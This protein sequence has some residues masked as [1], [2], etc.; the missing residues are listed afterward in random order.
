MKK[1][2]AIALAGAIMVTGASS[3]AMTTADFDRGMAKGLE[4]VNAG[5]YAEAKDEFQWFCDYNWWD[6]NYGQQQYALDCLGQAKAKAALGGGMTTQ[7]FDQGMARGI[8]YFNQGYYPEAKTEF[9]WFCDYNWGRMNPGQQQYALDYLGEAKRLVAEAQARAKAAEEQ[10]KAQQKQAQD[11]AKKADNVR[12]AKLF[13]V[14][15]RVRLDAFIV[16]K[17]GYVTEVDYNNGRV[18]V[19]WTDTYDAKGTK[20]TTLG[21]LFG[22]S[23]ETWHDAS[24]LDLI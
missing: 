18:R 19:K 3:F 8:Q 20:N 15:A 7:E 16:S 11:A 9:Q 22:G 1:L 14:G 10:K 6:M 2:F 13:Y 12:L 21:V 5:M 23:S 17:S 24:D 4:Y